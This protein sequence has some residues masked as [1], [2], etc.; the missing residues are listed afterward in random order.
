VIGAVAQVT[1][2]TYDK[3]TIIL[4]LDKNQTLTGLRFLALSDSPGFGQKANDPSYTGPSGKTFYEQFTGKNANDGFVAGET[5][6]AISGATITSK[7]VATLLSQGVYSAGNYLAEK[8]GGAASSGAAPVAQEQVTIFSFE[9]ALKDIAEGAGVAFSSIEE[10]GFDSSVY[11]HNMLIEKKALLKDANGKVVAVAVSLSGQTYSEEGGTVV[12][13]VNNERN[14]L[15][16][17]LLRLN[18]TPNLGQNTAKPSFYN[19]FVGK[20]ADQDFRKGADFDAV[21][22]ASIS[23]DCVADM[24]KVASYEAASLA[25]NH[26]GKAAPQG[27]ENY[28]LNEHYLEE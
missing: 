23:S 4:G 22:G 13:V 10:V 9:D 20:S 14:I 17:R 26:G 28:S 27:S 21:S 24:V 3:A 15:G 11:P 2:P 5:F 25:A 19:Q 8:H 12:A 7:G 6:D 16:A 18:D 1:G